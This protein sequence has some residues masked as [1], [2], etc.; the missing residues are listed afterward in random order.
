LWSTGAQRNVNLHQAGARSCVRIRHTHR[1]HIVLHCTHARYIILTSFPIDSPLG[2]YPRGRPSVRRRRV[3]LLNLSLLS[4]SASPP[5]VPLALPEPAAA[6]S[7]ECIRV[8]STTAVSAACVSSLARASHFMFVQFGK[9]FCF[10][11]P[12]SYADG[13]TATG[14]QSSSLDKDTFAELIG[15]ALRNR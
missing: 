10:G 13:G 3:V 12:R 14:P 2:A 6:T 9:K 15:A 1:T 8:P 5:Q 4:A 7:S 11:V